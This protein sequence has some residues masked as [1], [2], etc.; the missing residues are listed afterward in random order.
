M[1]MNRKTVLTSLFVLMISMIWLESPA[2]AQLQSQ[3]ESFLNKLEHMQFDHKGYDIMDR[4]SRVQPNPTQ[5]STPQFGEG[6][7]AGADGGSGKAPTMSST[8]QDQSYAPQDPVPYNVT[9]GVPN[10]QNIGPGSNGPCFPHWQCEPPALSSTAPVPP[11]DKHLTSSPVVKS[12]ARMPNPEAGA[13]LAL[14]SKINASNGMD[15]SVHALQRTIAT[16]AGADLAK[17]AHQQAKNAAAGGAGAAQGASEAMADAFN[18]T[19]LQMLVLSATP[20]PN[21][22][23]EAT[24]SACSA[25]QPIKTYN[26][27][28]YLVMQ[29][30]KN[31]YLPMAVLLLLPGAVLTQTKG[32]V[33]GGILSNQND[34][35]AVSPFTGILRSII[36]IFLIPA[37]QLIVSWTIDVGNSMQYEVSRHINYLN[38]Y[39]WGDEQVF[40]API[41]NAIHTLRPGASF[42]VLGKLTEGPEKESGLESQSPATIMLQTLV[43]STADAAAFGLV[44]L[45]AFQIAMACYLLLMGPVAAALY[46]WP[47]STGSLFTRV[48]AN[49]VDAMINLALWRFWWCIVLLCIDVRLGWLA[50]FDMYTVWEMLMFLAFLIILMY[51][52]FN[53]FDYKAGEMV[54]QIMSKSDQAVNQATSK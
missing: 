22:A 29:A 18:P 54:S 36:A 12:Q 6:G 27:S 25:S 32:L 4:K 33:S 51:V 1:R 40:R 8:P 26:N 14:M 15:Q 38:I 23:N 30:Y 43:N 9:G 46:A 28:I 10:G 17:G 24:G 37:S 35:D 7:F 13:V 48:F 47:G 52:P 21:V 16:V 5:S 31:I 11:T 42:P 49:W 41:E 50:G 34:E 2:Q 19:W 53:P 20:L 44:I 45:C 3:R 39:M